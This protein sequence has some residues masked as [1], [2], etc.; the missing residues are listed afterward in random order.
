MKPEW[1]IADVIPVESLNRA[2]HAILGMS[3]GF[4]ANSGRFLAN[5][6]RATL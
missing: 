6:C 2:E 1:L 4:L 5:S 3:L